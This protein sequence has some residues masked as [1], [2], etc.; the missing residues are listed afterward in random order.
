VFAAECPSRS[1]LDHLTSRWG[2]L[3]LAAL[4]EEMHRFSALRRRIGGVSEKMLAQTLTTLEHDGFVIR[5]AYPEV[6]PRVEYRLTP[7]GQEAATHV[8]ALA[9][10]AEQNVARVERARTAKPRAS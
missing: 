1:V 8:R 6:P 7:L 5:T 2:V 4:A 9:T 3:V 10:F